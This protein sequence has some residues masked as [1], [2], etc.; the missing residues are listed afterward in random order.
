MPKFEVSIEATITVNYAVEADN[1][2][3]AFKKSEKKLEDQ[4]AL[5]DIPIESLSTRK[6]FI[7]PL[8]GNYTGPIL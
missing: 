8:L 4:F 2:E 3:L 7:E 1:E 5:S 6:D